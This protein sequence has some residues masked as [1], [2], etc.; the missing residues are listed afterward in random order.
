MQKPKVV[1]KPP[2]PVRTACSTAAAIPA[3]VGNACAARDGFLVLH[4]H[5]NC[6][7]ECRD[8]PGMDSGILHSRLKGLATLHM[9]RHTGCLND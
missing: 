6:G 8:Y 5:S 7:S 9:V 2:V 4:T 3:V 1:A